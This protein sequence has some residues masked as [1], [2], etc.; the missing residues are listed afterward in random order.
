M[1]RTRRTRSR[2]V[3]FRPRPYGYVAERVPHPAPGKAAE[4]M[5]KSRLI[6]DHV[7]GPVITQIFNKETNQVTIRAAL[8]QDTPR[9]I[10]AL[11]KPP[12][13]RPFHSWDKAPWS[14]IHHLARIYLFA[15]TAGEGE[16]R[17]RRI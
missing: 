4:G 16:F 14:P 2:R 1:E 5:T 17:R 13:R 10:T 7:R 6:T 11:I 12:S 8:T 3:E 15:V 9:I